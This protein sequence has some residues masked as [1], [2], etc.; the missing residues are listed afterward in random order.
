MFYKKE[1]RCKMLM[2]GV[3]GLEISD[4]ASIMREALNIKLLKHKLQ[5]NSN[6]KKNY[7]WNCMETA[8]K[9]FKISSNQP[10]TITKNAGK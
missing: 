3:C 2:F 1:F 6:T 10:I 9:F 4:I 5:K 8:S 7:V